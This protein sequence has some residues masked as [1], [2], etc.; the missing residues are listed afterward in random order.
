M[1]VSVRGYWNSAGGGWTT[2]PVSG[3]LIVACS[4]FNNH[5]TVSGWTKNTNINYDN[6]GY[7]TLYTRTSNGNS[8]ND[9]PS[10]LAGYGFAIALQGG[11]YTPDVVNE[12][13]TNAAFGDSV[14]SVPITA[15]KN[16]QAPS[17]SDEL[18]V[19]FG[20]INDFGDGAFGYYGCYDFY[21]SGSGWNQVSNQYYTDFTYYDDSE[22]YITTQKIYT[23]Q[24]SSATNP[25]SNTMSPA[26][27][28]GNNH[29]KNALDGGAGGGSG[30]Q[31]L[32]KS[33]AVSGPTA[34]GPSIRR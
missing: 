19:F 22:Y 12:I 14:Y 5:I 21:I 29:F 11:S 28:F 24:L 1:A 20:W 7:W 30:I 26:D 9:N 10:A 25:G 33:T 27:Y 17:L 13:V 18:V 6:S 2:A 15:P 8:I 23:K 16:N 34:Y 31:I 3:D 4:L 32:I